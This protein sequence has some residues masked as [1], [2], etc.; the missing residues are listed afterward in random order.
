MQTAATAGLPETQD[1]GTSGPESHAAE[2][3]QVCNC[4]LELGSA[5]L[6]RQLFETRDLIIYSCSNDQLFVH[7]RIASRI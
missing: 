1:P 4:G 2:P 7:P 6:S 5:A 3:L